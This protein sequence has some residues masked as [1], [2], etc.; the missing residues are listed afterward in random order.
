VNRPLAP[1][2]LHLRPTRR[3]RWIG[4]IAVVAALQ[5]FILSPLQQRLNNL[6]Y[7]T[8]F[9][10]LR[11]HAPLPGGGDVVVVGIDDADLQTFAV[12]LAILHRQIGLFLQATASGKARA[13]GLDLVLPPNSAD[14]IQPGL[15]AALARGILTARNAAPLVLGLTTTPD[16]SARP[17]HAPFQRLAGTQGTGFIFLT[18]DDDLVIRRFDERIGKEGDAVPTLVGQLARALGHTPQ[19]GRVQ[20]ALGSTFPYIPLRQILVWQQSGDSAQLEK[21]FGGRTV[22]LGSVLEHDDQHKAPVPLAA[23]LPDAVTSHGVL[24]HAQQLR[25]VLADATIGE[26]SHTAVALIVIAIASIWW[27]PPSIAVWL[28]GMAIAL[29]AFAG[30]LLALRSGVA[31]PAPAL[32]IALLAALGSRTAF[33]ATLATRERKRLRA[34][35]GGLV[36][37][38]VLEEMLAGRLAPGR[39]GERRNVCVL[40]S[41]IRA[42]TTLSETMAPE[43]VTTLLNDYFKRMTKAI[44][45]HGGTLDKFIGDGIMAYFGAPH[46]AAN[47]CQQALDTARAMLAALAEFNHDQATRGQP[48]IAI[49]IGLH[50]GPAVIG[51]IGSPER[52]DYSAIG[53]TVNTASR[54]EGLTKDA[55]FPVL[56]SAAVVAQIDEDETLVPLGFK[57][58]K[59]RAAIEV[60]GW[61]PTEPKNVQES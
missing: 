2:S 3:Q 38:A 23:W 34:S 7:D 45:E 10:L 19:A 12:P 60:F 13:V 54:I 30:S 40:F 49:G 16:G 56:L 32:A 27:L 29:A 48:P 33:A 37:P 59:G 15:D 41:D 35:F 5:L 24:L 52:N 28:A 1:H 36:S 6:W 17:L 21:V 61:S 53:D 31:V 22:L 25:T 46:A 47:P 4:F 9:Q 55:G 43:A 42:F 39:A 8:A 14:G 57:A 58:V 18:R 50:Y 26:W 44:H 11:E 51:Y 20:Y